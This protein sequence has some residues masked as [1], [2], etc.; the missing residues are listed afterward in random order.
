MATNTPQQSPEAPLSFPKRVWRL[1]YPYWQSEEKW[2][3]WGLLILI[4][5][6]NLGGVY[7]LYLLNKWNQAF[8]DSLE[9]KNFLQVH[10][11]NN[12]IA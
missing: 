11:V 9:Q 3:A 5:A 4:L 2:R 10:T 1:T 12:T 7:L 8:Y 6:L